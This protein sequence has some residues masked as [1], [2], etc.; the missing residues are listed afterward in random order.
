MQNKWC[1]HI[2]SAILL[3]PATLYA[4]LCNIVVLVSEKLN[5]RFAPSE[6]TEWHSSHATRQRRETRFMMQPVQIQMS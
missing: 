5:S 3:L 1:V 4:L 2:A 6:R